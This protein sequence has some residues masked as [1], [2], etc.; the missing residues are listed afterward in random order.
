MSW[1][2][3]NSS[4]KFYQCTMAQAMKLRKSR[5]AKSVQ[6]L[7]LTACPF[8]ILICSNLFWMIKNYPN[9]VPNVFL[10][11]N[12]QILGVFFWICL[13]KNL[14]GWSEKLETWHVETWDPVWKKA[15]KWQFSPGSRSLWIWHLKIYKYF[16]NICITW[17]SKD[18]WIRFSRAM[19]NWSPQ[20]YSH[21]FC[22]LCEL[23]L[24][25][26]QFLLLQKTVFNSYP[27]MNWKWNCKGENI[28]IF[29]SE[30]FLAEE[31]GSQ[32]HN[33][34]K[35]LNSTFLKGLRHSALDH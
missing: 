12:F 14:N 20:F 23:Q 34:G 28:Q 16:I 1:Y 15:R 4:P 3:F 25:L 31:N 17:I 5:F 19:F 10:C 6:K 24:I 13:W 7:N 32:G 29:L 8:L 26:W 30:I 9:F 18:I 27:D 11:Q 21:L 33:F 2:R 35:I 22:S